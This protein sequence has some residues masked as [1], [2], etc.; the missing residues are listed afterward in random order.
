MVP[1]CNLEW[2]SSLKAGTIFLEPP[3]KKYEKLQ[4]LNSFHYNSTRL[5]NSLPRSLRDKTDASKDEWKSLLD[6]HLALIPDNPAIDGLV[7]EPCD[8]LLSSACNSI[9][10]WSRLLN[11]SDRRTVD[12]SLYISL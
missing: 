4:R 7:P 5:F 6:G 2:S 12:D 8:R 9:L 1:N 11:L 10:S 3:F